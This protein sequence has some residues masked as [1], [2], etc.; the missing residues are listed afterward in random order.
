[1][2][3][4]RQRETVAIKDVG[5]YSYYE[6]W[7]HSIIDLRLYYA[8]YLDGKTEEQVYAFLRKRYAEDPNYVTVLQNMIAR[9]RL[10]EKF[11][12]LVLNDNLVR[13]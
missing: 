5:G 12:L 2:R 4:P 6:S 13:L 3:F 10:K 8:F 11:K 1:M 9:E 7:R